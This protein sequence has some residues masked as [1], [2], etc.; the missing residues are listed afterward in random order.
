VVSA[1]GTNTSTAIVTIFK[2]D[3]LAGT[4]DSSGITTGSITLTSNAMNVGRD[5]TNTIS[6]PAGG[7]FEFK[8]I[9][10]GN[11]TNIHA[12]VDIEY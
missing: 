12:R 4:S 5:T 10:G 6:V 7:W 1:Y 8:V 3:S 11:A 9:S 2:A